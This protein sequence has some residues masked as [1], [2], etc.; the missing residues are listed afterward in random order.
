[1]PPVWVLTTIGLRV[2]L[3][4]LLFLSVAA[5]SDFI[6]RKPHHLGVLGK[7]LA[8]G[9]VWPLALISAAGRR[10]LFGAFIGG[11]IHHEDA[12]RADR[13]GSHL[14]RLRGPYR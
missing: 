14:E 6:F 13:A 1:M 7:R 2:W 10:A 3:A 9:L 11:R 12:C 4:V 8:M 5:L